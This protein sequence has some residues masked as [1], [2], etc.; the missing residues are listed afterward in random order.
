MRPVKLTMKGF[1]AFRDLTVVDFSDVELA[2]IVGPTGSGK[3][4]IIDGLT[5]ALFGSVARYDNASLVAPVI[6]QVSAEARIALDFEVAGKP[7]TAVRVVRRT[8]ATGA[9]TKEARLESGERVLAGRASEMGKKVEE[10]LGLNFS[11]FT[12]TVV[13]PQGRFAQFLHDKA[14]DRQELLRHLLDLGVYSRVGIEAR[15][16]SRAAAARLEELDNL[17]A[18]DAPTKQQIKEL[19]SKL[20]AM[21]TAQS[22]LESLRDMSSENAEKVNASQNEAERLE[23]LQQRLKACTTVP[24]DALTAASDIEIATAS[25]TVAEAAHQ[26]ASS[27]TVEARSAVNKGPDVAACRAILKEYEQ[28]SDLQSQLEQLETDEMDA[29]TAAERASQADNDAHRRLQEAQ[30]ELERHTTQNSAAVL[31][32]SLRVG[33][34]CPVCHQNVHELPHHPADIKVQEVKTRFERM[35]KE[36]EAARGHLQR[37]TEAKARIAAVRKAHSRRVAAQARQLAAAPEVSEVNEQL[38]G[39]AQLATELREAE[40]AER[41]ALHNVSKARRALAGLEGRERKARRLLTKA[42]D[43]LV[44]LSPPQP[45]ASLLIDWQEFA[46]WAQDT[47]L[48]VRDDLVTAQAAAASSRREEQ[49]LMEQARALCADYFEPAG[50]FER[51]AVGMAQAITGAERDHRDAVDK[52]EARQKLLARRK[53]VETRRIVSADLGRLLQSNGFESWLMEEAVATLTERASKRLLELSSDRYSFAAD[54]TSF[55][56]CDHS[57]GNEVRG[58]RTLSGGETFLASLALALALT[59]SQAEMAPEG[60]PGLESLFLDEGF[61]TLDAEVLDV[62]AAAIE[63]LGAAGRMV[64]VVTHIPELAERMPV[65]FEVTKTSESSS[66]DR[67]EG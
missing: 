42:R 28:F 4:T 45:G 56:I 54:G 66:V 50:D 13:L 65:R 62:V 58:A 40:D 11:R 1:A 32:G 5:F 63:G 60:A 7:Y 18:A 3:S 19:K 2:A 53:E 43:G 6:N 33:E 57:N 12:R 15:K 44:E 67:K 31:A 37:A 20:Q 17:L 38:I 34:K 26:A 10:L 59:D 24:R 51:L 35:A 8:T 48:G 22:E 16:R 55:L 27:V 21:A 41:S 49:R 61:G 23:S 14:S 25:L 9:T 29:I 36:R 30:S 52:R 39:A 46:A 64:C 47:T